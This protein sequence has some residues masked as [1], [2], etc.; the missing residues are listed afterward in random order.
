MLDWVNLETVA[1]A[2]AIAYLVLAMKESSLCWY[3][4]FFSTAIYV[5][6]Y[7]DVSLYMESALNLYYMAMAVY[8]W[9]QWQRGGDQNTGLSISRWN[10]SQHIR[11][12][13][14]IAA[15]TA[16]SGYMLD[17]NSDARLP[18]LDSFTTWAAVL[19]TVMVARKVIDN[20]LYWIVINGASIYLC[21]DR[22]LYQ[23]AALLVLY[24]VLSVI[25]YR[26]WLKSL[27]QQHLAANSIVDKVQLSAYATASANPR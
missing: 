13:L 14:L 9:Y 16:I 21:W 1:V 10:R 27:Q 8:G 17:T 2:L 11:A 4:A 15:A 23:T 22:E 24:I 18:Y 26:L 20:W 5:W 3:S 12:V 25:G 6:I 7:R 19:T